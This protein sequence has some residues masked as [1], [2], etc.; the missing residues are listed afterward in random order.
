MKVIIAGSRS[1]KDYNLI[2]SCINRLDLNISLIIS[3]GANGPDKL[4]EMYA[5][6]NNIPISQYL[7]DWN[8]FGKK[9]GILRNIEMAKNG[10]ILIAFHDL[11]SKGTKHM[12]DECINRGLICYVF[13]MNGNRIK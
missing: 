7:P 10:E 11:S 12:I 8:K 13:D 2:E 6:N 5:V 3:G 1:I 4:G 9:A